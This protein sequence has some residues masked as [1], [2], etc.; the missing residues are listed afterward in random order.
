MSTAF[1]RRTSGGA[2]LSLLRAGSVGGLKP[3]SNLTRETQLS[4]QLRSA[5]YGTGCYVPE[6]VLDNAEL[7][8]MVE[9]D[10]QWIVERTGISERRIAAPDETTSTMA[11]TAGRQACADAGLDPAE[12]DLII[13][14]TITPDHLTPASSCLVQQALGAKRAAAFDL[15]AACTGFL[16]AST[17][18]TGMITSG[19]YERVLV[20]GSETLSRF[21]DYTDRNTCILFGDGAG[22]AVFGPRR[23]GTGILYTK[24][25]ADGEYADL[26]RIYGGGSKQP[27]SLASLAARDHYLHVAGR[28][29]F[30]FATNVFVQMIEEALDACGMTQDDVAL[31]IPHQVNARIIDAAVRRLGLPT[32]KCFINIDRYGNTSSAS[33]PIALDEARRQG[34]LNP[35]DVAI[36]LGFGS[37]LTWGATVLKM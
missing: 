29:V 12:L 1:N 17:V 10:D 35:G 24:I 19:M 32:E 30:K 4:L 22:A 36:L 37:G 5:I 14:A 16:Y 18:A 31:V 8:R 2:D 34:K 28:Q 11:I 27:P 25:Y 23:D 20:I 7:E 21:T 3:R 6:R 15:S 26:L 9:T 13:V 33:V